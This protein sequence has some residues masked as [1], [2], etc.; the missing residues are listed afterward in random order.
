MMRHTDR[1]GPPGPRHSS[2]FAGTRQRQC[3]NAA[4][5]AGFSA[6]VSPHATESGYGYSSVM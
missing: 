1:N 3:S 2:V 4:R 5:K 6:T